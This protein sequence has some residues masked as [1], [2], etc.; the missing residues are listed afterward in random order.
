LLLRRGLLGRS[1]LGRRFL[2][3]ALLLRW[4]LRGP[5]VDESDG[6]FLGHVVA[7][8]VARQGGIGGAVGDVRAIA[9]GHDLH[10]AAARGVRAKGLDRLGLGPATRT[11]AIGRF[12]EQRDGGIHSR[13]E[14]LAR[15]AKL[16]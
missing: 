2:A 8:H 12:G 11:A 16:G 9:A 1:L 13:L 6:L 7:L 4:P 15:A 10:L 14:Y 3:P 5:R